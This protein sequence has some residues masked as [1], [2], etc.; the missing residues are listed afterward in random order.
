MNQDY[1]QRI[2]N[3]EAELER[4]LPRTEGSV[5]SE[6]AIAEEVFPYIGNKA[7]ASYDTLFAPLKDMLSRGGK[8][9]RPLLMTLICETLGGG[10][11]ALPIT[12]LVEFCHNASL[13]HDDI[14]DNSDERRGKPAVHHIYGVDTATNSGSFFYFLSLCCIESYK[15]QKEQLYKLWGDYLRKLHLGQ[16]M[17]ISWHRDVSFVPNV[18][19][20]YLMCGMKTGGL[21]GLAAELGAFAAGASTGTMRLVG[22]AAEKLGIAYQI[23][24]DIK[25]LTTG[26][27]G[28][29]RGDDVVEGKKSLPVLLYLTKFPEK[30]EKIFNCFCEAKENG[31]NAPETEEL[32]EILT[33][34][35][36]LTGAERIAQLIIKEVREV[37]NSPQYADMAANEEGRKL[38]DGLIDLIC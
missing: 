2:K 5:N 30:K 22:G 3:I 12:P 35:G 21:A 37:F 23:M 9:W 8:R 13:I 4:W 19:D 10:N 17:D 7:A 31:V 16:A 29:K 11:A 38:L 28:K 33:S 25:N 20:Y 6:F 26:V 24:D 32:I 15:G 34:S 14:E 18:D 36:V 27:P 1:I